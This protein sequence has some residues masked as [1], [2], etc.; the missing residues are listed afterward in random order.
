M[1]DVRIHEIE[2]VWT[3]DYL[4]NCLKDLLSILIIIIFFYYIIVLYRKLIK[5]LDK[6][7]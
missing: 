4:I 3:Y 1:N 6:N 5:F 7:S 2:T